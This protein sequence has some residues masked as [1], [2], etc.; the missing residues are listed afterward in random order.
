MGGHLQGASLLHR[1]RIQEQ[2]GNV[3]ARRASGGGFQFY[4]TWARTFLDDVEFA[5]IPNDADWRA[6]FPMDH[7]DT[8]RPQ[9]ISAVANTSFA[10]SPHAQ[11]GI[12][13]PRFASL[14]PLAAVIML[15]PPPAVASRE[16]RLPNKSSSS[17]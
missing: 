14:P 17:K 12:E 10:V 6:F 3:R 15:P 13:P 11:R 9:L 4:D 8:W 5:E 16:K 2:T 1:G 7:S